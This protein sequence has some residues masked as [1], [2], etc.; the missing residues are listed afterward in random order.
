MNHGLHYPV[1]EIQRIV[2]RK[3]ENLVAIDVHSSNLADDDSYSARVDYDG[4]ADDDH[5]KT[6]FF[7]FLLHMLMISREGR[8]EK[9]G[10]YLSGSCRYIN[11]GIN[12]NLLFL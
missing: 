2:S 11:W 6:I 4:Y 9:G 5:N 8:C 7:I 10:L 1:R 3:I 12:T